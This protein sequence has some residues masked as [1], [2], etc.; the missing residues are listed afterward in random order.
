MDIRKFKHRDHPFVKIG[1]NLQRFAN[2]EFI[3]GSANLS[4]IFL[5]KKRI[6]T[7]RSIPQ[8]IGIE[9]G[10][11]YDKSNRQRS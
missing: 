10:L 9:L 3:T 8:A 6:L 1:N 2:S 7:N 4:N 11:R 5:N